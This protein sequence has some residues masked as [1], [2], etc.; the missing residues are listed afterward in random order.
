[1]KRFPFLA[2]ALIAFAANSWAAP[3]VLLANES[4][5]EFI[6]KEMG[7][8]VSGEFKRF[9]A[10]LDIDLA[11]PEKSSAKLHIDIGSLTTGNDEADAIALDPNWLDKAHAPNALFTTKAI[12]LLAPGRYE[13][14]GSLS[15]RNKLR[16]MVIQFSSADQAS[17]KTLVSSDFIIK[18]SEFGIGGGEWN[19]GGVVSEDIQVKVRLLLAP[20]R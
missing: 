15:I 19:E 13:A 12:R 3:R 18:R 17:G 4:K 5:I 16:D 14:T 6:V 8:P 7:V 9:D 11:K 2:L 10:T 20:A 1:M